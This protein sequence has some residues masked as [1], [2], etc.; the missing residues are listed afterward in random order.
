MERCLAEL[1]Q[2]KIGGGKGGKITEEE[3]AMQG[4][5]SVQGF[6]MDP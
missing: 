4:E 5:E 1:K 6:I 3:E 2:L